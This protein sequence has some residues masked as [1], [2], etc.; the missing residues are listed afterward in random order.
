M[1]WWERSVVAPGKLP[2]LL[3]LSALVLAFAAA[4]T[5]TRLIR[6]GRGPFHDVSSAGGTHIHHVVP[7]VLLMLAGGFATLTPT[8]LPWAREVGAVVFG[9]GAGLTLDEFALLLYLHD[10]YWT[11]QGRRSV[12]AA[13]VTAALVALM[14]VG[15]TPFGVDEM[16]AA[17]RRNRALV[18]GVV[19]GDALLVLAVLWK[20]KPRVALVGVFVPLVALV[21]AVRL[22]RPTSPW[23]RRWYRH[24]PRALARARARAERYDAR[25]R[26]SGR[27]VQDLLGGTPDQGASR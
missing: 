14:L 22:A 1:S 5:V 23:A 13:M 9:V 21:G 10:V 3:A 11:E 7:G 17:E 8:G 19:G 27:R 12:E 24:R 25:W 15:V 4:R 26:A 18:T 16:S 2:L 6:A 20:G